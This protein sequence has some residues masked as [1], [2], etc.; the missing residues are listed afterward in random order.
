MLARKA[1]SSFCC[2]RKHRQHQPPLRGERQLAH[3][4]DQTERHMHL[5]ERRGAG[6]A[7]NQQ[8]EQAVAAVLHQSARGERQADAQQFSEALRQLTRAARRQSDT[9]P[10]RRG[11]RRP[12]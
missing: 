12:R 9:A 10:A 11:R 5:A 8:G 7:A 3:R 1:D 6:G 4:I 2:S